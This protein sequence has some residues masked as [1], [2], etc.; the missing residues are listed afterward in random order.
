[1]ENAKAPEMKFKLHLCLFLGGGLF[2]SLGDR[3]HIVCGVL[4][5]DDQSFFGQAWWVVPVFGFVS[6]GI[7]HLFRRLRSFCG[8]E[9]AAF[10]ARHLATS[11]AAFLLAY[12]ATGPLA[13][14]GLWLALL[15]L[16]WWILRV[17][18][19]PVRRSV[20]ILAF[21]L[22]VLGPLG[23]VLQ[24]ARGV[25][26]YTDPD[27]GP[28]PSWLFAVYLHGALVVPQAEAALER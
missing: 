14:W 8:E 28:M 7:Y 26:Q 12:A 21:L 11:S 27:W 13:D 19:W 25:F 15:L 4:T 9:R 22:A 3:V 6:V 23:E 18:L 2:I 17:T 5:Q 20:L 10:S 1:L 16:G 24:V